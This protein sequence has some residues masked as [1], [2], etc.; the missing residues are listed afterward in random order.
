[1]NSWED[2]LTINLDICI[3]SASDL[4]FLVDIKRTLKGQEFFSLA[5]WWERNQNVII[6]TMIQHN[7]KIDSTLLCPDF[8][9]SYWK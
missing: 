5:K 7:I 6:Q 4:Y 9:L 8:K 1:M 3:G 2:T